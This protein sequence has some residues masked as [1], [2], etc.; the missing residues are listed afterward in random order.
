MFSDS[1][2]VD[3]GAQLQGCKVVLKGNEKTFEGDGNA[4]LIMIVSQIFIYIYIY[5]SI[6]IDLNIGN[7]VYISY[8]S[9]FI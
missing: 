7:P 6:L 9:I 1:R 2:S 4:I 3:A 5:I 8:T